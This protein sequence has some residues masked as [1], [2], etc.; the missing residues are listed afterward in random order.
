MHGQEIK[1]ILLIVKT[2]HPTA[3]NLALELASWLEQRGICAKLV[4]HSCGHG[5]LDD[6]IV[7]RPDLILVLGG[8]GTILS[9]ARL[10]FELS[11]PLLGLNM[12]KVGFLAGI[13][14]KD[15]LAQMGVILKKGL[16]IQPR[17]VLQ[18]SLERASRVILSGVAV[19]DLVVNRGRLARLIHTE[20]LVEGEFLSH[21]RSDG[22]I[23]STP[24]GSSGYSLSAGG[25]IMDPRV[26]AYLVTPI[27]PIMNDMKP[28]ILPLASTCLLRLTGRVGERYMTVDGQEGFKL[29]YND[30]L[31][32][33]MSDKKLL[34]AGLPEQ[35]YFSNLRRKGFMGHAFQD[36]EGA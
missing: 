4:E 14:R 1:N 30:C 21:I 28:L 24:T 19:N 9:V 5:G 31:T 18:Y 7:Q 16:A 8:D 36:T 15:W 10:T 22:L 6:C 2:G 13:D 11:I 23:I 29:R 25:P 3:W 34:L 26:E 17:A 35:G 27:C 12:G 20:L 32:V 33:K